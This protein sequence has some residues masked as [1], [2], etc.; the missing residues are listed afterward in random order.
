M[1]SILLIGLGRFGKHLARQLSEYDHDILAIDNDEIKVNDVLPFV[2]NAE[3]GQFTNEAYIESLGV[4]N[5]DECIVALGNN[6][7]NSLEVTAL[8]KE[9]GAR[10]IISRA[11]S[12]SHAKLLRLVG[13]DE[14]IYP[15]K[16]MANR[17][18][19]KLSNKSVIDYFELTS[20]YSIYEIPVPTKW[21][22]KTI[23]EIGVRTRYNVSVLATRQKDSEDLKPIPKADYLF[24]NDETIMVFGNNEDVKK[25]INTV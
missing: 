24:S 18:A 1:K 4:R 6:F 3:I 17:L 25:L 10:H 20:S 22:G 16:E 12:D 21:Q 9:K 13:A 23:G 5:F 2:L 7:Q 19:V 8:L 15:E 11:D 14:T